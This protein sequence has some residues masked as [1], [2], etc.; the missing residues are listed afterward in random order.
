MLSTLAYD[1][2]PEPVAVSYYL[3]LRAF[4]WVAWNAD[5]SDSVN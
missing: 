2:Y 3:A 1:G 5:C 4:G